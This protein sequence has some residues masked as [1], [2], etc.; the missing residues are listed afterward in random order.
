LDE[1][2]S[3]GRSDT[4]KWLASVRQDILPNISRVWGTFYIERYGF[5][6]PNWLAITAVTM[7]AALPWIHWSRRFSLRTLLI[8]MTVVAAVLGLV[9]ALRGS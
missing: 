2:W 4:E 7:L 6:V 5:M 3:V 1:F 8:G 9:I